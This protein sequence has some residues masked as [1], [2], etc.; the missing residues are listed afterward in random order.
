MLHSLPPP[1]CKNTIHLSIKDDLLRITQRILCPI[2]EVNGLEPST[3]IKQISVLHSP[4][5]AV[6][7][8]RIHIDTKRSGLS[9]R[10]G[11]LTHFIPTSQKYRGPQVLVRARGP[12]GLQQRE[13]VGWSGAILCQIPEVRIWPGH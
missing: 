9:L 7:A 1:P 5:L 2:Q 11:P 8:E 10:A 4:R 12:A 13:R 6:R 3:E